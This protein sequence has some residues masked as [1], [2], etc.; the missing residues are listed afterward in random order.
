MPLRLRHLIP[1]VVLAFALHAIVGVGAFWQAPVSGAI[2]GGNGGLE[3]GLG[4]AGGAV[5]AA[6]PV[7]A[8][9]VFDVQPEQAD[10]AQPD[11]SAMPMPARELAPLAPDTAEIA[12]AVPVET[13]EVVADLPLEPAET[14]A[15]SATE[16]LARPLAET[17][18]EP[19]TPV[20]EAPVEA[21]SAVQ[22]AVETAVPVDAAIVP[23][24]EAVTPEPVTIETR[25]MEPVQPL[26]PDPVSRIAAL[27]PE[28]PPDPVAETEAARA[29][30]APDQVTVPAL[31]PA[32]VPAP[33][34]KPTP[35]KGQA[36]KEPARQ[37]TAA[38]PGKQKDAVAEK[39]PT[40]SGG[41]ARADPDAM[42]ATRAR[43]TSQGTAGAGGTSG[44]AENTGHANDAAAGGNPG[45]KRDYVAQLAAI[46]TRHKRYPRRARSRRQQ[47]VGHL[48]FAVDSGGRVIVS[49]LR[50]SSGHR[51]LDDEILAI[52]TRVGRFPPI[53]ADLGQS[54]V[55]VV[56]PIRFS[57]R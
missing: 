53:P 40:P 41:I 19:A 56:V 54:R 9:E 27:S 10:T 12:A 30:D 11:D 21:Q 24:I 33:V 22:P 50:K 51:L 49:S 18:V 32:P 4:M 34:R 25:P 46:L 47:G 3:V 15:E 16:T 38:K 31:V 37:K 7:D 13:A 23:V 28:A 39:G 36:R 45:A 52:L 44:G 57:L 5:G 20:R 48:F 17:V 43:N 1:A 42:P 8:A 35:P 14:A 55:D 26:S 2:G 29:A 6:R